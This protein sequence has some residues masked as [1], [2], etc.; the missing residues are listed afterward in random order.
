M[1]NGQGKFEACTL[2]SKFYI[3]VYSFINFLFSFDN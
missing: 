3:L 1:S 2:K